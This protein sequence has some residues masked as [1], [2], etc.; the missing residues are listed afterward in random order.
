MSKTSQKLLAPLQLLRPATFAPARASSIPRAGNQYSNSMPSGSAQDCR[1]P[2]DQGYEQGKSQ[3][4]RERSILAARGPFYD[5]A[6]MSKYMLASDVGQ[7]ERTT[8]AAHA[9]QHKPTGL[10]RHMDTTHQGILG[11]IPHSHRAS[12]MSGS[13][14]ASPNSLKHLLVNIPT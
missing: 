9:Y 14:T 6:R 7:G 10:A 4:G 8:T 12:C 5:G 11:Q 2:Y 1:R 13:E 3:I